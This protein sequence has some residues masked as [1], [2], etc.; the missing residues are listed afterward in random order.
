[1]WKTMK[2]QAETGAKY[3]YEKNVQ[4]LGKLQLLRDF[5]HSLKFSSP[6]LQVHGITNCLVE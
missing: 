2:H 1:M 4:N 5:P 6:V 3:S